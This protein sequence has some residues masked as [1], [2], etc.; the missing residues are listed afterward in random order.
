MQ[1][2]KGS[3]VAYVDSVLPTVWGIER[4][5]NHEKSFKQILAFA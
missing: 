3:T 2:N 4:F 1:Y 5:T